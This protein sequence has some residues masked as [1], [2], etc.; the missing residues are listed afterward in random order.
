MT[1]A[2]F[3]KDNLV[4]VVGLT[5]P[6]LLM[7]GFLAVSALP[8]SLTDPPKYDLVFATNDYPAAPAPVA[9]RLVVKDHVL[10]AQYNKIPGQTGNA[11]WKKLFV[12]EASTG[13]VRQLP[14]GFPPDMAAIESMREEPVASAAGLQLDSTVQSPDGYELSFGDRRGGGLLLEIFGGSRRYEA[15]LRKGG[16]SVPIPALAGESF[17]YGTAEFVGWVTGRG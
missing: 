14:L 8:Q 2:K 15:R 12:F 4:L 11:L 13:R 17:D 10:V 16:R 5:L 7:A 9:I 3:V 6:L 1:V